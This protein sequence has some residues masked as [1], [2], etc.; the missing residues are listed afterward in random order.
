MSHD[1]FKE[2]PYYGK[3]MQYYAEQADRKSIS[4]MYDR[5]RKLTTTIETE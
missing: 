5:V 2:T 4:E 3:V 1:K